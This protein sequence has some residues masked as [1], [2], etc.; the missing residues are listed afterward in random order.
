MKVRIKFSKYS[1]MKFIGHL[2]IMRFFQKLIR[3]AKID[4]C[5]TEGF[6]PHQIMTFAS[7][8]GVG[9]LSNAEYMDIVTE[10][11]LSTDEI[12]TRLNAETV[13]GLDILSVMV[14]PDNA[15]NAMA[16][17]A[18]ADYRIRFREGEEPLFSLKESVDEF[19]NRD[20]IPVEKKTKKGS[21]VLD[22]KESVL[23]FYVEEDGTVFLKAKSGSQENIKPELVMDALYQFKESTMDP[24]SFIVT[25]EEMYDENHKPLGDY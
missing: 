16:S 18:Y 19:F 9:I 4:I 8:L 11:N 7:P 20:S 21:R 5:Y 14:L 2:D 15:T 22:L 10:G 17:V 24:F 25:R 6:H 23:K 3:R 13:E 12:K 1:S